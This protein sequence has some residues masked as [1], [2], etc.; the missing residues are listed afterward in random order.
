MIFSQ[1]Y[2]ILRDALTVIR[3][4]L[5]PDG[6]PFSTVLTFVLNPKSITMGQ[7][8]GE[9]DMNTHEWYVVIQIITYERLSNLNIH[10]EYRELV[11]LYTWS[12]HTLFQAI[13]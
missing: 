2:E 6:F 7:L 3:G 12:R 5:A 8:Y 1:C 4:K 13:L 10:D 11:S 9:F